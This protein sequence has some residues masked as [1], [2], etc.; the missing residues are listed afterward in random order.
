MR[1]KNNL[2]TKGNMMRQRIT[3]TKRKLLFISVGLF[4][5]LFLTTGSAFAENFFI[6]KEKVPVEM[7]SII[8]AINL[9]QSFIIVAEK[10]IHITQF[11]MRNQNFKTMLLNDG[12]GKTKLV[13]FI[14]G[15]RVFV[16]GYLMENDEIVALSVQKK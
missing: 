5:V 7:E 15:Q 9:D 13:T 2:K 8:M 4:R 11:T 6:S 1:K 14:K 3:F 10:K 12:G 16:K